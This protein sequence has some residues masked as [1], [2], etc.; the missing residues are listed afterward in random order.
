MALK[1]EVLEMAREHG[2]KVTNVGEARIALALMQLGWHASQV[3]TQ[4]KL[5][6]FRLDFA[7]VRERMDIEADGWVHK[8]HD[9]KKRDKERDRQLE[10]WGW[11]TIRID[12][13]LPDAAV[14]LARVI[15]PL[16][17]N[18]YDNSVRAERRARDA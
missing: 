12:H 8:T 6:P 15:R 17:I 14:R 2:W 4:F 5:G 1:D 11:Q 9:Q 3:K 10:E 16:N 18:I 7:L 13:E